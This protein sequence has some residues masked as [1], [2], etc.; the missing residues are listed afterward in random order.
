MRAVKIRKLLRE[1]MMVLM[2]FCGDVAATGVVDVMTPAGA[3]ISCRPDFFMPEIRF[4][5]PRWGLNEA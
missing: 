4:N 2:R 1:V 5:Q 3:E